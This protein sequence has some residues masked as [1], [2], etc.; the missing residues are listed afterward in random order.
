VG[1][2]SE[3]GSDSGPT[4]LDQLIKDVESVNGG[5]IDDDIAVLLLS[6]HPGD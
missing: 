6:S 3:K 1:W 2:L 4:E 5:R